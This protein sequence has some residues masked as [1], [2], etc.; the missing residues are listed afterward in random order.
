MQAMLRLGALTLAAADA[1]VFVEGHIARRW[2][3]AR[4]TLALTILSA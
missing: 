1:I 3:T 2:A 4:T